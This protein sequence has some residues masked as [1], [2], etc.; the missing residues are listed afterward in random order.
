MKR[1]RQ[2]QTPDN[3]REVEEE[4]RCLKKEKEMISKKNFSVARKSENVGKNR[5][6]DILALNHSRV[7]LGCVFFFFPGKFEFFSD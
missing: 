7:V 6:N 5:Y 3:S 1:K 2:E 4:W